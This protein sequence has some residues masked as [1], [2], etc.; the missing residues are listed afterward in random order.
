MPRTVRLL[1]VLLLVLAAPDVL[2]QD[3]WTQADTEAVTTN[4]LDLRLDPSLEALTEGERIALDKLLEVGRIMQRLYEDQKHAE[5]AAVRERLVAASDEAT[6]YRLFRG[7]IGTSRANERVPFV[8]VGQEQAGKNV[9][10]DGVT[11]EELDAFLA[12]H[13]EA[14]A[15][16][17]DLRSVVRR[18]TAEH[19]AKDLATLRRHPGLDLL[20]PALRSRLND[21]AANPSPDGFYAVP[22]AVA[23]ADPI[24]EAHHLLLEASDAVRADDRDFAAYLQLRATDLLTSNY[25]AGDAAWVS[26]QFQNLNAQIG[27]YETYDDAL[28]GVKAFY[29]ASLLVRDA[30]RSE[31][32]A[33]ALTDIQ[34]LENSLPY[35]RQKR[36]RSQIPVGV[37]NVIADFGQARGTNTATILP[38]DADHARKYGRTI[39]LRYNIMTEPQLFE[40]AHARFCAA[41]AEDH[42]DELTLDGNFQ[43]TL[44]HEVGHYLGVDQ[45]Q[46]GRSLGDALQQYSDLFEEMKSDLAS[47]FVARQLHAS[48]YYSDEALRSVYASGILRVLQTRPPRRD[49]PYQTMQLMQWNYFLDQGLVALTPD[50]RLRIDYDRY[51]EVAE[52]LLRDVL[53]IQSAGDVDAA[54]AFVDRWTTWEE[55]V[56]GPIAEKLR[57]A[58]GGGYRLVR[59]AALGE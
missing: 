56:H 33:A 49:Q 31:R 5:S 18:A 6:L 21:L 28:F 20:H 38:N 39:L 57:N 29:S 3:G 22:Y 26:G 47:L 34:A 13:P 51:H 55:A 9:Y 52:G 42:C 54:A 23:F 1:A 4:I 14:R 35:E 40:G 7:P 30:D 8:S 44:W 12:Q 53:A 27:S 37:Y 17:L 24:M 45:T 10:P 48:G 43:R 32:L 58:P 2:A 50:G 19:L 16:I 41:V 15:S 46:D 11:R 59:Y 25:E 36:V